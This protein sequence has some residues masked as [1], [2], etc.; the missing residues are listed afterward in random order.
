MKRLV[1]GVVTSIGLLQQK[2]PQLKRLVTVGYFAYVDVERYLM[3]KIILY[4]RNKVIYD[5]IFPHVLLKY[6][7]QVNPVTIDL[8][9]LKHL[10]YQ[11]LTVLNGRKGVSYEIL[12]LFPLI[13]VYFN[14][15]ASLVI[16]AYVFVLEQFR[17]TNPADRLML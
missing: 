17:Q 14:I 5:H 15:A 13:A 7:D 12:A 6:F 1:V 3:A 4:G 11:H 16:D 9:V 2:R 8:V 10:F